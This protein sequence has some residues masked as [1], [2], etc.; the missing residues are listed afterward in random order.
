[1]KFTPEKGSVSLDA[2]FLNEEDGVC[3]IRISVTDSG[4]GISPE[5]QSRLF[6]SFAQAESSTTRKFGG[7]GLG[8]KISKSIVDM[9]GGEIWIESE[10]GK[11]ATFAFTIRAGIV[12]AKDDSPG[13]GREQTEEAQYDINGLFAG[14]NVLLAEDME[15]NREIV[16]ALLEPTLLG[17]D[18]AE[19][20]VVAVRM[21]SEAPE[22]Y[23]LIFMD[24]HMPEMDGYEATRGIR[25]L[26]I[27]KAKTIPILAMTANVFRED[28][29]KCI[30]SGMDD[31]IG[32]PLEFDDLMDKLRA[33]LL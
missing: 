23:D 20:G 29:E 11:G 30:A 27:P 9:L 17:I 4:I 32:K 16:Q 15:I 12:D 5:Q 7:S 21:F 31:H 14:F 2:R 26:D 19:N 25:E 22:K 8:L 33:Y 3:A 10:L 24:V 28:V 1:V 6:Q 18:C 13:A